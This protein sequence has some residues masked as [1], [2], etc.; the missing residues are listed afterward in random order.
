MPFLSLLFFS[1]LFHQNLFSQSVTQIKGNKVLIDL[2]GEIAEKGDYYFAL[3][4]YDKKRAL[5]KILKVRSD[6]AIGVIRKGN[7]KEKWHLLKAKKRT[8][9]KRKELEV[10]EKTVE[11]K[12]KN[13]LP[14]SLFGS[15]YYNLLD[16]KEKD[17]SLKGLDYGADF[18]FEYGSFLNKSVYSYFGLSYFRAFWQKDPK[19]FWSRQK[20]ESETDLSDEGSCLALLKDNCYLKADFL[21]ASLHLRHFISE[22]HFFKFYLGAGAGLAYP[23]KKQTNLVKKESIKWLSYLSLHLGLSFKLNHYSYLSFQAEYLKYLLSTGPLSL[24]SVKALTGISF[25]F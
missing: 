4:S 24:Q 20:N 11:L 12:S 1:F 25:R 15:F 14:Y 13:K 7:V 5:I 18:L 19:A 21:A 17:I 10:K 3:D 6:Q 9:L 22:T 8:Y 2:E 23:V 16:V